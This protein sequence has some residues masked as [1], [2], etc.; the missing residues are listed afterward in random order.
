M[1]KAT[2]LI[3]TLQRL[4]QERGGEDVDVLPQEMLLLLAADHPGLLREQENRQQIIRDIVK[5]KRDAGAPLG[6]VFFRDVWPSALA[7]LKGHRRLRA[8]LEEYCHERR[9]SG[10]DDIEIGKFL[11]WLEGKGE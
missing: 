2:E 3:A 1:P 7:A 4:M 11:D 10:I 6:S 9:G 8:R 5:A